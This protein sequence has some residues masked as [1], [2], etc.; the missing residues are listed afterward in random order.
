MKYFNPSKFLY[1]FFKNKDIILNN[2]ENY[3]KD[4]NVT[5]PVIKPLTKEES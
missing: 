4:T 2:I 5:K 1:D 3:T